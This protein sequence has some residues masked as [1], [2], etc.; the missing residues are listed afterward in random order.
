MLE[1]I[2]NLL[3]PRTKLMPESLFIVEL[4]TNEICFTDAYNHS[5]SI[6][7]DDIGEFWVETNDTGPLFTDVWFVLISSSSNSRY[8]FPQGATGEQAILDFLFKFPNFDFESFN[9]AMSCVEVQQFL[10]WRHAT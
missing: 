6:R 2:R 7:I 9:S 8:P 5:S 1:W 4:K 3:K 10:C